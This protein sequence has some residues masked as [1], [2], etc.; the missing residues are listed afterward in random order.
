MVSVFTHVINYIPSLDLYADSTAQYIPFGLL[1]IGESDKPAIHTADF[2]GIR[3]TPPTDYR[4]NRSRLRMSL[5]IHEDGSADGETNNEEAGVF[6]AGV[7]AAMA[8]LPPDMKETVVRGILS[9]GGYTGTGTIIKSDQRELTERYA[10]G[11]KFHINSA[12]N[13]PG[14]GAVYLTPIFSNAVPVAMAPAELSAPE[15][16]HD[17]PCYGGISDEEI[18]IELPESVKVTALP[19]DV[20]VSIKNLSYDSAYLQKG[21]TVTAIRRFEDRTPANLCTPDD[22]RE[23]RDIARAVLKDIRSQLIYE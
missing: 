16:K 23:F 14:P 15:S 11:S 9:R 17:Y 20:H 5:Q 21:R 3:H 6:T 8:N 4:A 22:D 2:T 7:R 19:K 12:I 1:P 10:Y 18:T 13:L